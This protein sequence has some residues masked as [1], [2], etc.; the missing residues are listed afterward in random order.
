MPTT[1]P[2]ITLSPSFPIQHFTF[3]SKRSEMQC[4]IVLV[5]LGGRDQGAIGHLFAT[6]RTRGLSY[7]YVIT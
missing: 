1:S 4:I 2:S 5:S 3:I 6:P 7:Y